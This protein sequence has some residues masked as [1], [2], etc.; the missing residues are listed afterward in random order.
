MLRGRDI[1]KFGYDYADLWLI[2]TLPSL[3]V[4]IEDYPS[5]KQHLITFGIDRLKQTGE[6]G[7]RKKTNNKWFETQDSI[8]YWEDFSKQKIIYPEIT[9]FLNFYC[10]T[11]GF[12]TNNKCFIL[13]GENIH[14]LTAFLNSSLFKFCFRNNFPELLGGSREL[15]KVFLEELNI[16]KVDDKIDNKC[17]AIINQI[18][19]NKL[20]AREILSLEKELDELVFTLY[21]LTDEEKSQVGFITIQ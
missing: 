10:D 4:N 1:K 3:K 7:S 16:I 6:L 20:Q 13:T 5:V 12:M 11:K 14:F 2:A 15:R 9:K 17:K 19:E 21:A 8:S 18:I